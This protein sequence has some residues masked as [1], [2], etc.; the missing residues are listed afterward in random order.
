M[1]MIGKN[2]WTSES[3]ENYINYHQHCIEANTDVL[4]KIQNYIEERLPQNAKENKKSP[5]KAQKSK[6][7]KISLPN[8]EKK[9]NKYQPHN[10]MSP[11]AASNKHILAQATSPKAQKQISH[12]EINKS[13]KKIKLVEDQKQQ[14]SIKQP[15]NKYYG[16]NLQK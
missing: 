14:V 4:H 10:Y 16:Q 7:K 5:Q 12:V 13:S 11:K 8:E 1:N 9:E 6:E 2:P 3:Q 15:S